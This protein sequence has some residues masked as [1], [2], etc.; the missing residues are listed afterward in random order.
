MKFD[1][2]HGAATQTVTAANGGLDTVDQDVSVANQDCSA[3]AAALSQSPVVQS[4]VQG[5][6]A[7]VVTPTGEAT[8]HSGRSATSNTSQALNHFAA[9]D[10]QMSQ[11]ANGAESGVSRPDM[12]GGGLTWRRVLSM[13]WSLTTLMRCV[14]QHRL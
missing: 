6:Q 5:F 13:W 3:L 7:E 11:Q 2:Q 12:P 10:Q 4:A 1:I 9:G 14:A 8:L